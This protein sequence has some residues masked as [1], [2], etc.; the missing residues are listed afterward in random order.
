MEALTS[1]YLPQRALIARVLGTGI[2]VMAL[3]VFVL[4]AILAVTHAP[5]W[6]LATVVLLY[7]LGFI[8]LAVWANRAAWIVR[9]DGAGYRVRFIRGAGVRAARWTDVE[10]LS[11]TEPGGFPC[12]TLTL[13]DGRATNIPVQAIEADREQFMRDV[14]D[15]LKATQPP[16]QP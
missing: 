12:V 4:T 3:T 1:T 11:A 7:I 2:I 10:E 13:I 15:R 14:R 9:F 8:A 16:L 5:E 6:V